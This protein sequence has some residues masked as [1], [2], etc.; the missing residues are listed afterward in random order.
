M[1]KS[2]VVVM[3]IALA[4]FAFAAGFVYGRYYEQ[5]RNPINKLENLLK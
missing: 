1:N 4:I 5:Q 3:V 2:G